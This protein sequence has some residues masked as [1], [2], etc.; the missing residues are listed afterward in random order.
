MPVPLLTCR[1]MTTLYRILPADEWRAAQAAGSFAG[2]AHDRRDGFIHLSTQQQVRETAAKH[3]AGQAELVLLAVRG[4][5]L[6]AALAGALRWEA[7][8]GGE[9]FPHLYASLPL[10]AVER[11]H[12]LP[13]GG[14]GKH[15]FPPL[16]P[17]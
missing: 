16:G 8:R 12:A 15:V 10:D 1:V 13:L 11:V 4:D 9:R 7:S 14:D 5:K 6:S 17:A 3:Y 2:S